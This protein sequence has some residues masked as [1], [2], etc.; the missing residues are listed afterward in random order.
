LIITN[1][2]KLFQILVN[3][4]H[5]AYDAVINTNNTE[6]TILIR[7]YIKDKHAVI[8][9]SDNGEGI[10]P[11]DLVKIFSFGFTTKSTGHGYGLHS[12]ALSAKQL[13]GSLKAES[14]GK[15]KGATFTLVLPLVLEEEIL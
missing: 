14:P 15:N 4:I 10:Y 12:S 11:K 6:K 1:R 8:S 3:L 5:N 7:T 9:I 13:G 2:I